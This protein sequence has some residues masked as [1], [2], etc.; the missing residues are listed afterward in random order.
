MS[1]NEGDH[2]SG[3]Y[4]I[5]SSKKDIYGANSNVN[6]PR[7]NSYLRERNQG[8][9]RDENIQFKFGDAQFRGEIDSKGSKHDQSFKEYN[10][11]SG[12]I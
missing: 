12:E 2:M 6:L 10:R 11:S 3:N 4:D 1:M 7:S 5:Q 8:E 9:A